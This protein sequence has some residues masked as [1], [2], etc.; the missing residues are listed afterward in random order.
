[1][2]DDSVITLAMTQLSESVSGE[3]GICKK[4]N[5]FK[6]PQNYILTFIVLLLY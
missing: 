3:V 6:D 4:I 5:K 1:M 2:I